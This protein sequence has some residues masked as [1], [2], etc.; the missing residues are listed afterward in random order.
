M[1]SLLYHAFGVK[2]FRYL[3]TRYEGGE[4]VF[5]LE[6]EKEPEVP[7]GQK[8]RRHG[9]RWRTV[10][11]VSIGLKPVVLKVKVPRWLN[12]TTGEEFEQDP[13]F[14]EAY[15]KITRALARLIVD[16]AR[17]M[18]LADI[19]GW[20]SLSWD[21]VRTVVQ[22]RLEKDYRRIGYRKVLAIAIDELYLGRA[23]KYVTLV[24]DLQ[25]GRIIWVEQGR[26]SQALREFWRRF[27][28]SGAQLK[29][30][31]MD[32]SGAYA[33]SVRA[34]APHAIMTFDRFHVV[35]LMN[36]RLDDLRRELARE[37]HDHN[38]KEAIKGLRW[39]LLHRRDNLEKDAAKRLE[40]S[41]ALNEPLQCAYLLKEELAELW[42][43]KDGREA[44]G[45]LREW[46]AKAK[47]D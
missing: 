27:K 17:F 13:P 37:A 35:K 41:L 16:L 22:R 26:G 23:R 11:S 36:E 12:T 14:V 31:A 28:L 44:W 43:Q 20:L 10:R 5:E 1:K 45:F 39:L 15:T 29:A 6:P 8:L 4:I 33:A 38:A 46:C 34:H 25:S 18:T 30:V 9:F 7:A 19:A 24:I 3:R 21:T 40:R 32:M 47:A 2:G 42:E